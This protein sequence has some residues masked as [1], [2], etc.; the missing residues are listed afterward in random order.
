LEVRLYEAE[1]FNVSTRARMDALELQVTNLG[2]FQA[3][4]R[5]TFDEVDRHLARHRRELKTLVQED[6]DMAK[7]FDVNTG[8]L[9][10]SLSAIEAKIES[11]V[12]KLCH[13]SP[14]S[15]LSGKGTSDSP[16]ELEYADGDTPT[17]VPVENVTPLPVPTPSVAPQDS[18][19]KNAPPVHRDALRLIEGVEEGDGYI[20]MS[21]RALDELRVLCERDAEDALSETHHD[22]MMELQAADSEVPEAGPSRSDPIEEYVGV[23]R[24]FRR[25]VA[26]R[27]RRSDPTRGLRHPLGSPKEHKLR[28]RAFFDRQRRAREQLGLR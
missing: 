2:T 19:A 11:M 28:D 10:D 4:V 23:V 8:V 25:Q 3:G 24:D 16:Y 12:D 26:R 18:D 27:T 20:G 14:K 13:C 17:E 21:E 1:N 5:T 9:C 7:K 15:P 6:E 22:Q